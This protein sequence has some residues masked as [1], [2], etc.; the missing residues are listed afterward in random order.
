VSHFTLSL[1][2]IGGKSITLIAAKVNSRKMLEIGILVF[3]NAIATASVITLLL[4]WTA[5]SIAQSAGITA[6]KA[7]ELKQVTDK[8]SF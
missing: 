2:F 5:E 7:K 8:F 1:L 3:L 4:M 6:N